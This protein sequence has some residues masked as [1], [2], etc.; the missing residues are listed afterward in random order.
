MILTLDVGNTQ[1]FGGVFDGEEVKLRFRKT[2]A[3]VLTSDELGIFLKQVLRENG[4][5]PEDIK[6]IGI[7][8]VVPDL[9]RTIVNC[10]GKYFNIDPFIISSQTE[11]TLTYQGR[12]LDGLGADRVANAVGAMALHPGEDLIIIDFGTANTYCAISAKGEYLGGAIQIGIATSLNALTQNT[13]QLSKVEILNPGAAGGLTTATQ[14]QSGMYY[15]NLGAI[16]EFVARLQNECFKGAKVKVLGTGG[17][18]RMYEDEK[19]FD[20]YL[21]DLVIYGIKV[22]LERAKKEA[23]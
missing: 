1:I 17:M 2:S 3:G 9:L 5:K 10:C 22:A 21:P 16:K 7:S 8:S 20:Q 19:I 6:D 15:G 11:K 4:V 14:L 23:K 13:A 12:P 18:A